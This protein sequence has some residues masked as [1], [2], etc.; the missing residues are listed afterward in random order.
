M[1]TGQCSSSA[2]RVS[3][4][5]CARGLPLQQVEFRNAGLRSGMKGEVPPA[6]D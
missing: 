2:S 6:L 4:E 3:R 5:K 1:N